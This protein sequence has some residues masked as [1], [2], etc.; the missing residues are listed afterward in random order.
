MTQS[1]N[2]EKMLRGELYHAFTPELI[3]ERQR[4][5]NACKKLNNAKEGSRREL[6]G[7]WRE[8]VSPFLPLVNNFSVWRAGRR[9]KI[10]RLPELSV[11]VDLY[12]QRFQLEKTMM[13]N[14]MTIPG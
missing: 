7:L 14:L 2:K 5:A 11:I 10:V 9:L 6:V 4:C 1:I 8:C 3:R 13:A 12:L